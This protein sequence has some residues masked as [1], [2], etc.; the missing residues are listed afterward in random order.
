MFVDE[1]G[2]NTDMVRRYGRA[3]AKARVIDHAPLNTPKSTT[4]VASMRLNGATAHSTLSGSMTGERFLAF[5][6]ETLIPTLEPGTYV[7]MDNLGSHH[8]KGVEDCLRAAGAIPLYLPPY[9]PDLTPIEMLWSK[10][11]AFLRMRRIRSVDRLPLAIADA[12]SLVRP[13]H[14]AGWFASAGYS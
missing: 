4:I 11:K 14:S 2:V 3:R 5:L 9:S 10:I 7:V 12:F 6:K 8:V 13:V 1:S